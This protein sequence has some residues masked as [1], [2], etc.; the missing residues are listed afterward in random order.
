[1]SARLPTLALSS[2]A[3]CL[4]VAL[5][6]DGGEDSLGCEPGEVREC[7]CGG[8]EPAGFQ[9]CSDDGVSFGPCGCG[10]DLDTDAD[11]DADDEPDAQCVGR[12]DF[13]PCEVVTEPDRSYD[14]C[15]NQNCVSPGCGDATCNVPGPHFPPPPD[16]PRDDFLRTEPV[17]GEPV[18][19]DEATGLEWQGCPAG[20]AGAECDE[21]EIVLL[22]SREAV[23]WCDALTW[24]SRDD[25]RLPDEWELQ[26]IVDYSVS[27]PAID[28][29]AFPGTPTFNAFHGSSTYPYHGPGSDHGFVDSNQG[30]T[31]FGSES[32]TESTPQ[33][34][35]CVR[36]DPS[37]H[38]ER[39]ERDLADEE[40]PVVRDL[41]TGLEWQG[42][43]RGQTG[44]SCEGE[45][46][47]TNWAQAVAHCEDLVWAGLDDWRLPGAKELRSIADN[48]LTQ[49][50]LS[51]LDP[52]VFPA[53]AAS[54]SQGIALWS[55]V[56][57]VAA[58]PGDWAWIL[59]ANRNLTWKDKNPESYEL[60]Y[61]LCVRD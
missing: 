32:T 43:P 59:G 58:P 8:G 61:A 14:I 7:P 3:A 10:G 2:F 36:G 38:G 51:P 49:G 45:A 18:V 15:V 9:T 13:T 50:A 60:V 23:A 17:I 44:P 54:E 26:S 30:F 24:A 1:V 21:G 16:G 55:A 20:L 46:E 57:V 41:V 34:L 33:A 29:E 5:G 28:V 4:A 27:H 31:G 39:F 42:C 52:A 53:S 22:W 40:N 6:C 48:R 35:L 47:K 12:D 56:T 19:L 25:W 37:P 11:G